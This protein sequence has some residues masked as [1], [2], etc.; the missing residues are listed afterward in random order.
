MFPSMLYIYSHFTTIWLLCYRSVSTTARLEC[1]YV[2]TFF[3]NLR[4]IGVG[5]L[6]TQQHAS[7]SQGQICPHNGTCCH[8]E[9]EVADQTCYLIQSQ[10][11]DSGPASPSTDTIT[12]GAWQGSHWSISLHLTCRLYPEKDPQQKQESNLGLP[13]SRLTPYHQANKVVMEIRDTCP[14]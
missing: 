9:I 14:I 1:K 5:R 6:T 4:E 7:V 3:S 11:A 2:K 8:T 13:L 10:Y 12:P